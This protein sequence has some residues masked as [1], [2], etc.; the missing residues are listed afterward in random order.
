MVEASLSYHEYLIE[1]YNKE[2]LGWR[3]KYSIVAKIAHELANVDSVIPEDDRQIM[4]NIVHKEAK[5]FSTPRKI[6]KKAQRLR[7]IVGD[8]LDEQTLAGLTYDVEQ[9]TAALSQLT[10]EMGAEH[11]E[12]PHTNNSVHEGWRGA[13]EGKGKQKA[14]GTQ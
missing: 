5:I 12:L 6:T 11:P 4:R 3:E 14:E 7:Y 13:G 9:A 2:G 8:V 10:A 1:D